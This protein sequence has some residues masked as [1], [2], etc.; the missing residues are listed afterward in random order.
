MQFFLIGPTVPYRAARSPFAYHRVPSANDD[1]QTVLYRDSDSVLALYM[2]QME[3]GNSMPIIIIEALLIMLFAVL[4]LFIGKRVA[5][6]IL[7]IICDVE[8]A[9]GEIMYE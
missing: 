7:N 1:L 4:V 3:F 2:R 5:M 8:N 6:W 9:G